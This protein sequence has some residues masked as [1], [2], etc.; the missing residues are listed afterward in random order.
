M[1]VNPLVFETNAY[2]IP[3]P[4]LVFLTNFLPSNLSFI[5]GFQPVYA[6]SPLLVLPYLCKSSYFSISMVFDKASITIQLAFF[7]DGVNIHYTT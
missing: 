1:G 6:P 4:R 3:P 7:P 5:S 2:A